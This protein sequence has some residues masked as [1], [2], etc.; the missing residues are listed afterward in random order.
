MEQKA[1]HTVYGYVRLNYTGD[2]MIGDIINIIYQYYVIKLASKIL[3]S[4]EQ[5]AFM[6]F[7]FDELSHQKENESIKSLGTDLLYRAS[8]NKYRASKYHELCRDKG[9]TITI[10]HN[11]F[12]HVFGVYLSKSFTI[13]NNG[14]VDANAFVFSIRPNIKAYGF[15]SDKRRDEHNAVWHNGNDS[16]GPL[17]GPYSDI[18]IQ[19][20]CNERSHS[21]HKAY[22]W[23]FDTN[24]VFGGRTFK[25]KDYEVFSVRK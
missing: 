1:I 23:E 21:G 17:F 25:I 2:N 4:E 11:E 22:T 18:Y 8:D 3:D 9:S 12:D 13:A 14:V 6:N 10:I 15:T 24:V 16:Y 19:D 7:L 5:L 20:K